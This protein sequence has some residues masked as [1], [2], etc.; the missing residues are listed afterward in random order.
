M[1]ETAWTPPPPIPQ[2]DVSTLVSN[3]MHII[4]A[5]QASPTN[6]TTTSDKKCHT[7]TENQEAM[8]IGLA[9]VTCPDC[10]PIMWTK[11]FSTTK[12]PDA[13]CFHLKEQMQQWALAQRTIIDGVVHIPEQLLTNIK[14]LWFNPGGGPHKYHVDRWG[15]T[16]MC[17]IPYEP[18]VWDKIRAKEDTVKAT[19]T[20]RTFSKKLKRSKGSQR[21]PPST[22]NNFLLALDT[23]CALITAAKMG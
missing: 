12:N 16:I 17:C 9:C 20:T 7:Y 3:M 13:F 21:K 14:T 1:L 5:S 23:F 18:G 11:C 15:L 2:V 4:S 10:V 19:A 8:V 22:H 6:P